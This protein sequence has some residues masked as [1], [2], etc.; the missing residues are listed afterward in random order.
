ME[1][2]KMLKCWSSS[3]PQV[4]LLL[5]VYTSSGQSYIGSW[6]SAMT[7]RLEAARISWALETNRPILMLWSV[8]THDLSMYIWVSLYVCMSSIGNMC[9]NTRTHTQAA[10]FQ[11]WYMVRC[12]IWKIWHMMEEKE[13]TQTKITCSYLYSLAEH[14]QII[15]III[16]YII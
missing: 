9:R 13:K 10:D 1:R 14:M 11:I 7:V 3:F 6:W 15:Y 5:W 2:P 16:Y 4:K 12:M 8:Q